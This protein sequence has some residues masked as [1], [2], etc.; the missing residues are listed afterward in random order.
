MRQE[1]ES[2]AAFLERLM[3]ASRQF[4]PYDP[5][6]EENKGTVAMTCIY[7]SAPDIRRKLQRMEGLQ[8]KSLHKLVQVVE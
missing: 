1:K 6:K 2:P 4:T 8:E 5:S 7:Q 3:E